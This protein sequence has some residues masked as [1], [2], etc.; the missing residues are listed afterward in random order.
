MKFLRLHYIYLA[1]IIIFFFIGYVLVENSSGGGAFD[2]VHIFHNYQLFEKNNLLIEFPWIEYESTSLPLYYFITSLLFNFT[3]S[4]ELR[5]FNLVIALLCFFIFYRTLKLVFKNKAIFFK[6][7]HLLLMASTILLSP[8]LRTSTFWGLEEVIGIFCLL[9]SIF[10]FKSFELKRSN[11]N[12]LMCIFFT[13]LSFYTRQ[14]YIFLMAF[15]FFNLIDLKKIIE[16]KNFII[17]FYFVFFLLPALYIFYIWGHVFPPHSVIIT[18]RFKLLLITNIP[19]IFNII[20]VYILPFTF[21]MIKDAYKIKDLIFSK[22]YLFI[23]FYFF[24]LL[25]L[26]MIDIPSNGGGAV[27]KILIF[28]FQKGYVFNL[29]FSLSSTI[30]FIIICHI[31]L[32]SKKLGLFFILIIFTFLNIGQVFQEY[33]DPIVFIFM[34]VFYPYPL[35]NQK[36]VNQF[37]LLI[38]TYHLVFLMFALIYYYKII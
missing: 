28:L 35:L 1:F 10:Y 7:H 4:L 3:D 18:D 25:L 23:I 38:P 17:I 19:F 13:C 27:S 37:S 2:I 26:N 30:S 15:I 12:L 11:Y 33:F 21:F 6:K 31:Y 22:K 24:N 9:F 32:I 34:L 16:K 14:S 29:M 20:L 5:V 36:K 8:Y